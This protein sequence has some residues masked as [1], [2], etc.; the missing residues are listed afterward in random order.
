MALQ[1][2]LGEMYDHS[3]GVK[4]NDIYPFILVFFEYPSSE[5]H[6]E[7]STNMDGG[8]GR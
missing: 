3:E 2:N 5:E 8:L 1:F 6:E 4:E 7:F